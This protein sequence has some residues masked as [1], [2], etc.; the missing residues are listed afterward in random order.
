MHICNE[1]RNN[2]KILRNM[3]MREKYAFQILVDALTD[4]LLNGGRS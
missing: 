3:R 2:V 4:G 1:K